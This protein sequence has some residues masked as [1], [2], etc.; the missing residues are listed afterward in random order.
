PEGG[1]AALGAKRVT[2]FAIA[3]SRGAEV[4]RDLLGTDR[5]KVVVGNRFKS[6]TWIRRQQFCWAHLRRDFQ[7]MIDRGGEAAEVGRRLMEHSDAL[8]RWWYRV[9]EGTLP[10]SSFRLYVSWRR[11]D[12]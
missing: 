12:R 5:R 4:A 11:T 7:A 2:V 9:R 10:R 8:S 6:Y 1:P 3:T